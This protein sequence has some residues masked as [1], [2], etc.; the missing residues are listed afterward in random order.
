MYT[1][2]TYIEKYAHGKNADGN[3][4]KNTASNQKAGNTCCKQTSTKCA[5]DYVDDPS[6]D[7]TPKIGSLPNHF[8]VH[9]D[10]PH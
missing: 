4:S 6:K 3:I 1:Y 10:V 5:D 2:I 9:T 7:D 8:V